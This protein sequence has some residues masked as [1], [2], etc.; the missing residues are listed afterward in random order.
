M[1]HHFA[2]QLIHVI[3][4]T[5]TRAY[6][7]PP[8]IQNPLYTY[9]STVAKS[10]DGKIYIAGG[11]VDHVHCLISLPQALSLSS[12]MQAIK[13]NSSRWIKQQ[14]SID[15]NF[16]WEDGYTAMSVQHD[17]IDPVCEY[18]NNEE[19]RHANLTYSAELSKILTLQNIQYE[20]KYFL[21]KTHSKVLMHLIWSTKNRVPFLDGGIRVNLYQKITDVVSK[22]GGAVH[23]IGGVED[24][25][26][27]LIETPRNMA[28]SDVINDIKVS[29]SHW[30]ISKGQPY[31]D[32]HWQIGYG[33]FSVSLSTMPAVQQ[34]IANQEEHHKSSTF[35]DEWNDFISGK[36]TLK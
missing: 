29:S 17:R 36:G 7:I 12:L 6:K 33:A 11:H 14:P 31:Q 1:G 20:E 9:L 16:A 24:H 35:A 32:F 19:Q 4:S 26:H 13:G 18:I 10:K 27:V 30:V 15:P 3:W 8:A 21:T 23:A 2:Q 22:I 34:Y 5:K 25:V 28:L